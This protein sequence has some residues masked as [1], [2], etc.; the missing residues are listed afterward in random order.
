M[1]QMTHKS[2]GGNRCFQIVSSCR[3][4][5][6]G[7]NYIGDPDLTPVL[8][9]WLRPQDIGFAQPSKNCNVPRRVSTLSGVVMAGG[10]S[11]VIFIFGAVCAC[12]VVTASP[13]ESAAIRIRVRAISELFP[14]SI[15][16]LFCYRPIDLFIPLL[17]QL[18]A[19]DSKAS[20]HT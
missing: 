2:R 19:N 9:C 15:S 11:V 3:L 13:Q 20:K 5:F 17:G 1:L 8:K 18:L 16:S 6:D 10:M 7:F 4:K 14:I 12:A